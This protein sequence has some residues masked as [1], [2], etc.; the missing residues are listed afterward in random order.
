MWRSFLSLCLAAFLG[1]TMILA[2]SASAQEKVE[3]VNSIKSSAQD[4][5]SG[6]SGER[7]PAMQYFVAAILST[8]VL[9]VVCAPSRKGYM[10]S[11]D[12]DG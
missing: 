2:P 4:A 7:T 8:L 3:R 5:M 1:L 12:R 9:F 11:G 6:D 10:Q